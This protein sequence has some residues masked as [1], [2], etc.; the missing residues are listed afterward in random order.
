MNIYN[1]YI[2]YH[3]DNLKLYSKSVI[4][5]Q[6][7]SFY[8]LYGT[9]E[10]G[11]DLKELSNLLNLT[12]TRKDKN[13]LEVSR[14]NH[15]MMGFPMVATDKFINILIKAGYTVITVDQ[16]KELNNKTSRKVSNIYSSST[17]IN[18][19]NKIV[20][21]T[22]AVCVYL[23]Y[24]KSTTSSELY[25]FVGMTGFD[26][27]TGKILINQIIPKR[28]DKEIS[29]DETI[30]FI[31]SIQPREI[32]IVENNTTELVSTYN[33]NMIHEYL[34]VNK[35][36]I[37]IKKYDNKYSKLKYQEEFLNEIYKN[38][39]SMIGIIEKL[40]LENNDYA[41][42]SLILL[43]DFI[44]NYSDKLIENIKLPETLLDSNYMTLGNNA[45][46]QL[47]ILDV[48]NYNYTDNVK[49]KSLYDIVNNAMT[50]MGKRY[51]K[52]VLISPFIKYKDIQKN[53]DLVDTFIKLQIKLSD[54]LILIPDL[55]KQLRKMNLNK[56]HPSEMADL[57]ESI[58]VIIFVYEIM[59]KNKISQ[60][61]T[62]NNIIQELNK[63]KQELTKIF[64]MIELKK[65]IL[66]DIKSNF[67]N[68]NVYTDLD[69]LNNKFDN[70]SNNIENIKNY[71][72]QILKNKCKI[73]KILKNP[74]HISN[75]K[76][77][78]YF[79][80]MTKIRYDILKQHFKVNNT[81]VIDNIKYDF[82]IFVATQ[83]KN[84][85]KLI[86][87]NEK[88]NIEN[89]NKKSN[90]EYDDNLNDVEIEM[91]NLVKKYYIEKQT[92]IYNKYNE[93]FNEVSNIITHIDYIHSNVIT[94]E[95]YNY[96]KPI[97]NTTTDTSYVIAHDLRH[98]IVERLIDYEYIPHNINIGKELKGML[99]YGVNSSGKSILMKAIG[100]S[101]IMAQCGM[102]VPATYFEFNPYESLYTRITGNDNLFKGLSSFALE[103]KELNAILNRA[104]HKS[105]IIGDEVCRGTEHISGNS[106][107][108]STLV[109]LSQVNATYIFATHLHELLNLDCIKKLTNLKAFHLSIH[110]NN[111]NELVYDR[112]LKEG[113]GD[114]IYGIL[115]AKNLINNKEF[116]DRAV[117]IKNELLN[118]DGSLIPNK[119]SRYNGDI[120]MIKCQ[121]CNKPNNLNTHHINHQKDCVNDF[122]KDK[123]HIKKNSSANLTV[124]CEE[125]HKQLHKN[126]IDIIGTVMTDKGRQ[127]ISSKTTSNKTK[128][129]TNST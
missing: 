24:V 121:I 103:M 27:S 54:K 60:F 8:E 109:Q 2:K 30:R 29:I 52:Q 55:D 65:N 115:V 110:V 90:I 47:S 113:S 38:H 102:Y 42:I 34:N 97:I 96:I 18:S 31:N 99:I 114:N 3:N 37:K 112:K 57:I 123:P 11:P 91:L 21:A 68:V 14:S 9:N 26:A 32:F 43:L 78:G 35:E 127:L 85:V 67:F 119:I 58:D 76:T 33:I 10:E 111:N 13:I 28:T 22:Y 81:F 1:E 39:R 49:F 95:K 118:T 20:D 71:F 12:L 117:S 122:V 92:E 116:I 63:F 73:N 129:K 36:I 77:E 74:I 124:L 45:I 72:E 125:C 128:C 19:N 59:M 17:Y 75:T 15:Y 100:L 69:A 41:R 5:M 89:I 44:R 51:I 70:Y 62:K 50:P 56:L 25:L 126:E 53:L 48:D 23:E 93:L 79:L 40:N 86:I 61:V 7:G 16:E 6:V 80:K 108:A 87:K 105:L 94:A 106:L 64:N 98:P 104:T 4:L 88:R 66:S 107:V 84:N 120:Y 82:N 83:Q 101:I 46:Y